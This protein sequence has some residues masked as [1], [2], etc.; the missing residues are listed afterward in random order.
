L[1]GL[2]TSG[3]ITT[4]IA[5]VYTKNGPKRTVTKC[6]DTPSEPNSMLARLSQPPTLY[7]IDQNSLPSHANFFRMLTLSTRYIILEKFTPRRPALRFLHSTPS[8]HM[9][10]AATFKKPSL[11]PTSLLHR[12]PWRPPVGVSAD[13]IYITLDDGRRLLDAVGGAAVACIGNN[14]PA[15][16]QAIK[17]QVDKVS[18]MVK[19]F[20]S[21]SRPL[22]D[23]VLQMCTACNCRMNPQRLWRRSWLIPVAVRL[24]CAV[25]RLEVR[26]VY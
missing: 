8:S 3:G 10:L 16:I 20:L 23:P 17:D 13:G 19:L 15:V 24:H 14:H 9:A 1:T 21:V 12:T 22:V 5:T 2:Q 4:K 11:K 6:V 25:S 18:C 26:S 7:P